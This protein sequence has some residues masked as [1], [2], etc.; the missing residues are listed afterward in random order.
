MSKAT[1]KKA[2][3]KTKGM[4]AD[5]VK[6]A[7]A[8]AKEAAKAAKEAAKAKEQKEKEAAK[9]KQ[10]Q[11]AKAAGM[12]LIV[13]VEKGRLTADHITGVMAIKDMQDKLAEGFNLSSTGLTMKKGVEPTDDDWGFIIGGFL[14]ANEGFKKAAGSSMWAAG[15]ACLIVRATRGPEDAANLIGNIAKERGIEPHSVRIAEAACSFYPHEERNEDASFTMHV[16]AMHYS[17]GGTAIKKPTVLKMIEEAATG[18]EVVVVGRDGKENHRAEPISIK[19]FRGRLQE[20][21]GKKPSSSNGDSVDHGTYFYV[22]SETGEVFESKGLDKAACKA[23]MHIV[24]DPKAGTVLNAK[25]DAH[26]TIPPL[27]KE[28]EGQSLADEDKAEAKKQD[29]AEKKK[30]ESKK[31]EDTSLA[32]IPD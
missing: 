15:D 17:K 25:G 9:E 8:R 6:K 26:Y 7:A 18:K 24:I 10:A 23:G 20:K 27:H 19:E 4:A 5:I 14:Q 2:E 30:K 11:Q 12:K 28:P 13:S 22:H 29:K 1:K 31:E 32:S 16:E 21:T 3:P